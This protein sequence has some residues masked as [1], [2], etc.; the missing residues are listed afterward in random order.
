M[1]G[2]PAASRPALAAMLAILTLIMPAHPALAVV[3]GAWTELAVSGPHPPYRRDTGVVVDPVRD[4]L[5]VH[6]GGGETWALDLVP[7]TTWTKLDVPAYRDS[8]FERG[9]YDPAGDRMVIVDSEM[10]VSVLS[11]A[12][13]VAWTPLAPAGTPPPPRS[14]FAVTRDELRN[15]LILFGGGPYTGVFSDLWALTLDGTPT[16]T[17]IAATGPIAT[18][19]GALAFYDPAA[20]RVIVGTGVP[21]FNATT[22]NDGFYAANLAGAPQWSLLVLHGTHPSGRMLTAGAYDPFLRRMVMFSG[23]YP[24]VEDD[25]FHALDMTGPLEWSA[26]A[27]AGTPP[28]QWWSGAAAYWPGG[29]GTVFYEGHGAGDLSRTWFLSTPVPDGPPEVFA[30]TPLH[31]AMGDTVKIEG[32]HL[33]D[34]TDVY[35]ND[36]PAP[37]LGAT[38]AE[39]VTRV[40]EGAANGPIAVLNPT[41]EAISAGTFVVDAPV[42]GLSA[43]SRFAMRVI[44]NPS[45]AGR[46]RV[47]LTLPEGARASV[48]LLDLAGREVEHGE[49]GG[50]GRTEIEFGA[51]HKLAPGLYFV[52]AARAGVTVTRRVVVLL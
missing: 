30:F 52:R 50:E 8:V 9:L 21:D 2:R 32:R 13:P 19:W 43:G 46:V 16:W 7:G 47:S 22:T 42:A 12:N 1:H 34:V 48:S 6:A 27:P 29:R 35:F 39:L 5:L 51:D 18:S 15:R 11:L 38:F 49:T 40:P 33:H 36:V 44:A 4:R 28:P 20:D 24:N 31:G 23:F 41:D 45:P 25:V 26:L 10:R 14:F 17:Q 3:D 37:I